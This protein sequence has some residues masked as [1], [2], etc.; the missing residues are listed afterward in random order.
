MKTIQQLTTK[1]QSVAVQKPKK[2]YSDDTKH[3]NY[4]LDTI[5]EGVNKERL[6]TKYKPLKKHTVAIRLRQSKCT[7]TDLDYLLKKCEEI[8]YTKAFFG[9]TKTQNPSGK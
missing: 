4:C 1:Y 5:H 7:R 8:G 3:F 2:N 9:L 6:G